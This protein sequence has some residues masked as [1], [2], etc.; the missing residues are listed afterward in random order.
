M[1]KMCDIRNKQFHYLNVIYIN[2]DL[3]KKKKGSLR[4]IVS[5]LLTRNL[6]WKILGCHSLHNIEMEHLPL[7]PESYIRMEDVESIMYSYVNI[8]TYR[9]L[10]LTTSNTRK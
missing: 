8:L 5:N 1:S 9:N 6:Q 3:G 2:K 4:S 7:L 10:N